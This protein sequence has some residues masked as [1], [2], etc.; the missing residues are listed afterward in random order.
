MMRFRRALAILAVVVLAA[1]GGSTGWIDSH[2]TWDSGTDPV[3]PADAVQP[4]TGWGA[5]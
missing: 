3:L 5:D 1:G 4:D 2:N